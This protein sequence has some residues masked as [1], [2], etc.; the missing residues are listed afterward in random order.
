MIFGGRWVSLEFADTLFSFWMVEVVVLV[1]FVCWLTKS[2]WGK[3][4]KGTVVTRR[5]GKPARRA[6]QKQAKRKS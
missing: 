1:A 3:R 5:P 4:G 2:S 6:K